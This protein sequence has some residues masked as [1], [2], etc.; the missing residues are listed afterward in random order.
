MFDRPFTFLIQNLAFTF[1][2]DL[3]IFQPNPGR[4][5]RERA[6]RR[7]GAPQIYRG[8]RADHLTIPLQPKRSGHDRGRINIHLT[9]SDGAHWT[10]AS[11]D[12]ADLA[13]RA[14]QFGERFCVWMLDRVWPLDLEVAAAEGFF[15]ML[16]NEAAASSLQSF[17]VNPPRQ[18]R[19]RPKEIEDRAL[20]LLELFPPNAID[21]RLVR[22]MYGNAPVP[23]IRVIGDQV[24]TGR[25]VYYDEGLGGQPAGWYRMPDDRE[26]TELCDEV[27]AE[28]LSPGVRELIHVVARELQVDLR[29]DRLSFASSVAP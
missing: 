7:F 18:F 4:A 6:R 27:I 2:G 9:W 10:V 29:L 26:I 28:V 20:E 5:E 12:P 21:G 8:Q 13:M 19:A 24:E 15:A 1:R 11:L 25:M 14:E 22:E 3:I 17:V 16:P 23:L